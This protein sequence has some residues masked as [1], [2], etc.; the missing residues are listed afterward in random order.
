MNELSIPQIPSV[1]AMDAT[2]REA[3]A[4]EFVLLLASRTNRYT[5]GDSSSVRIETAERLARGALYCV[6]LHIRLSPGGESGGQSVR[7]LFEA[8]VKD[9]RRLA[10]H[11]MLLLKQA[12][13]NRPPIENIGFGDTLASLPQ[14]FRAY[15]TAF[16]AQEIPCDIDYPLCHPVPESL[17]GV[18]YVN[19]YIR[20][21]LVESAFLRMFPAPLLALVYERSFGGD[22]GLLVNLYAPVAEAALGRVLAGKAVSNLLTDALDRALIWRRMNGVPESEALGALEQAAKSVC[23]ELNI[24]GALESDYLLQ[25]SLALLPR[26][27]ACE[28]E[29][30]YRGIFASN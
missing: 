25:T 17:L 23:G 4:E 21:L 8:G 2:R 18:E 27:R 15:D 6:D 13:A 28:A 29:P 14:F 10:R 20:R 12:E 19:E 22:G 11:G 3:F 7:S 30:G 9:A 26:L 16:F 1:L 24:S 5:M